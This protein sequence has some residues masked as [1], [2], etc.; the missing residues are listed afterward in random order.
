MHKI[1]DLNQIINKI[2]NEFFLKFVE[3]LFEMENDQRHQTHIQTNNQNVILSNHVISRH[4][5]SMIT[6]HIISYN[7]ISRHIM[8][9]NIIT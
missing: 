3:T 5:N 1:K 9:Y 4:I 7:V 2:N 8:S 6:Y